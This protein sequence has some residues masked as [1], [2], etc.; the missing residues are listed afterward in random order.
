MFG[1]RIL[2]LS[3][4]LSLAVFIMV[5]GLCG[6]VS[7]ADLD[8]QFSGNAPICPRWAY[9]P[10]VWEDN[11]NTQQSTIELVDGYLS[12]AIPVGAVIIDSPW[13]TAYNSFQWDNQRYPDP[14]GMIDYLHSKGVKVVVW[15]TGFVNTDSP[16]YDYVKKAGFAVDDGANHKWWKGEGVHIDFTNPEAKEWWHKKLDKI[17]AMGI[18]GWKVDGGASA[19]DETVKTSKG[20]LTKAEFRKYYYADMADYTLEKKPDGIVLARPYSYQ[21]GSGFF[22]PKSKCVVGWCGD[23]RGNWEGMRLQQDNLYRSAEAGYSALAVEV[24]GFWE[25]KSDSKQLLRYAHFGALMPIM[26][27]GGMNGGLTNHLPWFHGNDTVGNY[28]GYATLHSELVPYLFSYGVE[29]NKTGI[30]IVRDSDRQKGQHKLGEE[31]FVPVITSKD[32]KRRITFPDD[33]IWID[34]QNDFQSWYLY[35]GGSSVEVS[36]PHYICPMYIKAGAIIPL[37]VKNSQ[38]GHGDAA[39]AGKQTVLIYPMGKSEFL[40]HKPTGDGIDYTD[41]MIAVDEAK[42]LIS[43]SGSVEDS[44]IFRIKCF[45][46]PKEVAGVD[47]W[48]YDQEKRFLIAR[49]KGTNFEVRIKDMAGYSVFN[50]ES[51]EVV[52]RLDLLLTPGSYLTPEQGKA[53][54][55]E[56]MKNC[57]TLNEWK[58]RAKRVRENI[59]VGAKLWP[60]PKKGPLNSIIHSKREYDG[61]TVENAAFESF[62]GFFVTGNLYRPKGKDGPFAAVLCPHG[63]FAR[64][65]FRDNMQYR[66]ASLAKMG[67]V[68]FS[69]DMV[70]WGESGKLGWYHNFSPT[71]VSMQIWNSIRAIDFIESLED[72]DPE[73]IGITGASGGGTQTFMTAAIDERIAVSVPVVMASSYFFGGC[74]CESY[75]PVH[76]CETLTTSNIEIAALAAPRPQLL[77]SDGADWTQNTPYIEYP[78]IKNIY[79]FYQ[80]EDKIENLHLVDEVHDYGPSKRAGMYKFM[81]KYLDLSLDE[82]A[83][84]DG[85]IDESFVVIEKPEQMYVFDKEH[86]LP[87]HAALPFTVFVEAEWFEIK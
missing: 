76:K 23:F 64:G 3:L 18:D 26:I 57:K 32:E 70:G 9:E 20:I 13:A 29:A 24:G 82:L 19:L 30:S 65:R 27:N 8:E 33:G 60:L 28:R 46:K 62:P 25:D 40:F 16:D 47:S 87:E 81:A 4:S 44:Y 58:A 17:M 15:L 68:V 69:Y 35:K 56:N 53:Q 5:C 77:I 21:G 73:R 22:S 36:V 45:A 31:I 39:S 51:I 52:K 14:Q 59:L 55:E 85:S 66:C 41:V 86:P 79:G 1:K 50:P 11:A 78:Y 71:V 48:D 2:S 42:G 34:Y 72:V 61:Y 7:A 84:E 54:L 38:A 10:W 12:R 75:M 49:R 74:I 83:K 80:A 43:V 37:N 63:H 6:M 67:A